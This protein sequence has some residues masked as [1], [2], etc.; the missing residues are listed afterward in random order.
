[1]QDRVLRSGAISKKCDTAVCRVLIRSRYGSLSLSQNVEKL[2]FAVHAAEH[3]ERQNV[4]HSDRLTPSKPSKCELHKVAFCCHHG[5][6][7][8]NLRADRRCHYY[9]VE[10]SH[11]H[12]LSALKR[13]FHYI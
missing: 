10:P 7:T 2:Q 4:V 9:H 13:R 1:M 11:K 3:L 12:T 6:K 5:Y 8:A